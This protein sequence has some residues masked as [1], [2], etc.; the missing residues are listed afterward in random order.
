MLP[1]GIPKWMKK[2][3]KALPDTYTTELTEIDDNLDPAAGAVLAINGP[4]KVKNRDVA[5]CTEIHFSMDPSGQINGIECWKS[6]TML[7]DVHD[8]KLMGKL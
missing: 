6:Y 3:E 2:L 4:W 1:N 7:Q 5:E 8:Q